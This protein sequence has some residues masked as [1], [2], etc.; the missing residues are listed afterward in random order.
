MEP[1]KR[2]RHTVDASFHLTMAALEP[3]PNTPAPNKTNTVSVVCERDKKEYIL[4]NLS[5]DHLLQQALD[6]VF[7]EGEE[8]TFHTNGELNVH[9]TGYEMPESDYDED[10]M[11]D[12]EGSEAES[13]DEEEDLSPPGSEGKL[14]NKRKGQLDVN[15]TG[16]KLKLNEE[17]K[18]PSAIKAKNQEQKKDDQA[19]QK[20]KP[21]PKHE[22]NDKQ[23][24]KQEQPKGK[25]QANGKGFKPA[26]LG[27][28]DSDLD[29]E[30]DNDDNDDDD[31]ESDDVNMLMNDFDDDDDDD[32]VDEDDDDDEDD[33]DEEDDMDE[34]E[35]A[36][37]AKKF[38]AKHKPSDFKSDKKPEAPKSAQNTPFKSQGGQGQGQN[39]QSRKGTP[40]PQKQ[41]PV[42]PG[43][44]HHGGG[45]GFTPK[46]KPGHPGSGQKKPPNTGP[47]SGQKF[48]GPP[49]SEKKGNKFQKNL[50]KKP[51]MSNKK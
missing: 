14:K 20:P 26:S 19:N 25:A 15:L 5:Q 24:K 48:N 43:Q 16:K 23:N 21:A 17:S 7:I 4:C 37:A 47:K 41:S 11:F 2:V 33:E 39:N 44:Q 3:K 22:T 36:E 32:D 31:M 30:E 12:L 49:N 35:N 8:V 34:E 51:W 9:L 10:D 28:G 38:L 1:G 29:D 46:Q 6:I 42:K 45:G 27:L 50:H 18:P 40:H 13:I